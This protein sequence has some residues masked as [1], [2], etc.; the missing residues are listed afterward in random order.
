VSALLLV[1][2]V[3]PLLFGTNQIFDKG[4]GSRTEK[5]RTA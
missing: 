4:K 5:S 3:S 1:V 2:D